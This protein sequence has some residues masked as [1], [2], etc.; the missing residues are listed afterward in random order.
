MNKNN[1]ILI[2]EKIR[3]LAS[4]KNLFINKKYNKA[5]REIEKYLDK[6]PTDYFGVFL[7]AQICRAL[8]ENEL[9][10]ELF[11]EISQSN[12]NNKY[13]ALVELG[14]I[15]ESFGKTKEAM[16]YYLKA[17]SDSPNDEIFAKFAVLRI[18]RGKRMYKEAKEI[19]EQIPDSYDE[20]KKLE[21][22]RIY[23][24]EEDLVKMAITLS[25]IN[26]TNDERFN[27]EIFL[28]KGRLE[29]AFLSRADALKFFEEARDTHKKDYIYYK[30]YYEEARMYY[31]NHDDK[32]AL[33]ILKNIEGEN[34]Y[35]SGKDKL[36]LGL[37][38]L[39]TGDIK[40]AYKF[41][42]KAVITCQDNYLEEAKSHLADIKLELGLFQEALDI[43][44]S[45]EQKTVSVYFK[46][47]ATCIRMKNY[48]QGYNYL[49]ELKSFY[50]KIEKNQSY[51]NSFLLLS[52]LTGRK[53]EKVNNTY[54]EKQLIS[55]DIKS[56]NEHKNTTTNC[57]IDFSFEEL[58]EKVRDRLENKYQINS[59]I[60]DVYDLVL[61]SSFYYEGEF[62]NI[63][64]V[65]VEPG[66]NNILTL[67]P[68]LKGG[69]KK[70]MIKSELLNNEK[71]KIKKISQID[72]FKNKYKL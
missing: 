65:I 11:L 70:D 3:E 18:Y 13:S 49:L 63:I 52:K 12:A 43:F 33:E 29:A 39:R 27:R 20:Q 16:E 47:V 2:R 42:E 8:D 48:E 26:Y 72:K 51:I 61:D 6:Y 66:T 71:V 41:L 55:Y 22:V 14:K 54:F 57:L 56:L 10:E 59:E 5:L 46:K 58:L 28:E 7:K 4:I 9:A 40:T 25:K 36:L 64:R 19:L 15:K 35:L 32:K 50:P 68:S 23:R 69:L 30:S 53:V 38:Y 67:Y 34:N 21:L 62:T 1:N 31:E 44:N 37:I 17:I 60:M 45:L 24:D